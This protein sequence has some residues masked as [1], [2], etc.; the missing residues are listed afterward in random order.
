VFGRIGE[1]DGAR[2]FGEFLAPRV[3]T[4]RELPEVRLDLKEFEATMTFLV[5]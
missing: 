1:L 4:A 3:L 5:A 2:I